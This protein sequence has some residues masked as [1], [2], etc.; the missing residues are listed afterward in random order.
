MKL[1]DKVE[2]FQKAKQ[3]DQGW[4]NIEDIKYQPKKSNKGN[5]KRECPGAEEYQSLAW[6]STTSNP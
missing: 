5:G 2:I 1:G 4:N 3:K 6:K